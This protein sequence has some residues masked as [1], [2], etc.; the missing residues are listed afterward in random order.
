V[1]RRE[2]LSAVRDRINLESANTGVTVTLSNDDLVFTSNSA[3]SAAIVE[4][5]LTSGTF[6]VT[7]ATET[8][9]RMGTTATLS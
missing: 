1:T 2:P 4:I 8:A 7:G 5:V 6:N 3:G 9:P